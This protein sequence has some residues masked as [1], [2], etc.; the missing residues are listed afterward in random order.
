MGR[1]KGLFKLETVDDIAFFCFL[2]MLI[3][4]GLAW[5][6]DWLGWL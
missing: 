3:C 2:G 5:V 1:Y 6:F 4:L